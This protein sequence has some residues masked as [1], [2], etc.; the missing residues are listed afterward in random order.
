[1]RKNSRSSIAKLARTLKIPTTNLYY[2]L[3]SFENTFIKKMVSLVD[4]ESLKLKRVFVFLEGKNSYFVVEKYSNKINN[5]YRHYNGFILE[6]V[7]ENF[8]QIASLKRKLNRLQVK[9]EFSPIKQVIKQESWV[10][11][12]SFEPKYKNL[13]IL[14][15]K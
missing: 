11:D 7:F 14:Q 10:P 2:K 4:F 15:Q 9:H 13:E 12:Q 8:S 3:H 6:L 5:M 1:M